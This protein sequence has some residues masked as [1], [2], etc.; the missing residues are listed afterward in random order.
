MGSYIARYAEDSTAL[1]G[2]FVCFSKVDG[3]F[4]NSTGCTENASKTRKVAWNADSALFTTI[5]AATS[6][7]WALDATTEVASFTE[8]TI[9]TTALSAPRTRSRL[10]P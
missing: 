4:V 9:A 7:E 1:E 5:R 6:A 3:S 2:A 10:R 8:A